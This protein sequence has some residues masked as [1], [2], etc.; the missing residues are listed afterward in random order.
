MGLF[1]RLLGNQP[2]KLPAGARVYV[3]GYGPMRDQYCVR[4]RAG[5]ELSPADKRIGPVFNT[6]IG[7][8]MYAAWVNGEG[9]LNWDVNGVGKP[10]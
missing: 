5:L 9:A 3:D 8:E 7:A 10:V 2:P 6:D 1:G 4:V